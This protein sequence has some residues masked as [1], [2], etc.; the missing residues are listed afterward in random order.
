MK[1]NRA[2]GA[3]QHGVEAMSMAAAMPFAAMITL[4]HRLP[5][6]AEALASST[7]WR[8]PEVLRMTSEKVQASGQAASVLVGALTASQQAITGCALAQANANLALAM[9]PYGTATDFQTFASSSMK[10][11]SDLTQT[12]GHIGS[13][14]VATSLRPAHSKVTANAKRLSAKKRLV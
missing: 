2:K 5:M 3:A 13:K 6:L 14:A 4:S 7:A 9:R 1:R 11:L 12:L 8:D 10:R